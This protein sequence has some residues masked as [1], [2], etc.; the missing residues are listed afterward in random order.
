MAEPHAT[1]RPGAVSEAPAER[2]RVLLPRPFDQPFDYAVPPERRVAPGDYVRVPLGQRDA[3][4]VVWADPE[5]AAAAED[6]PPAERLRPI[7]HIHDAPPMPAVVRRFVAWVAGYTLAPAGAV[8]RMAISVPAALA[9]PRPKLGL[10][11]VPDAGWGRVKATAQRRRVL[12]MAAERPGLTATDLAREAG[13]G[14][15]VVRGLVDAGLLAQHP[16]PEPG[17]DAVPDTRS[18]LAGLSA[19]Q[20]AA[21]TE[22]V[23]RIRDGGYSATLLDGVT[24]SGKTAVYFEAIAAA[25][26]RGE[27]VLVLLPEI[28][29]T[30]HLFARFAERF[31]AAPAA[32]HSDLSSSQRRRTWRAVA[33]GRARVV[34]GARSALFLPYPNLGLIVVDEEHESAFKQEEGVI[35]H[36]RDMAVARAWLGG[37]PAVLASA[38]PSLETMMNVEAGR[39]HRVSL[40]ERVGAAVLPDIAT[41]DLKRDRPPARAWLAEPVRAGIRDALA[42][43]E[44]AMLFLNRRGYAP[45]VLCRACGF[46]LQCPNCTAWLVEHR[47]TGRLACHHC[48]LASPRPAACPDC[49]AE[50]MLVPCGP[51]IERI[52]EEVAYLFPE[53]RRAVVA[54]DTVPGPEAAAAFI[55]QVQQGAVDIVIGTQ[56][57]AKGHHFPGLTF[58]G[59]VDADLGL[60]GGD[61][62]AG[63]RTYQVLHQVA[64]RAGR[65]HRP[66]RVLLQTHEPE[67]PVLQALEAGDRDGFL[68]AEAHQR[69][70]AGMPPFTRLVAL[71]V[72]AAD[73]DSAAATAEALSRAAPAVAEVRILGP[74]D[75]P[76][77][78]L[79]GR[80]RKRFSVVAPRTFNVQTLVRHWLA[81][82]KVPNNTRLYVDVDPYSFL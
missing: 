2:A 59:V 23:A 19:D 21:A 47:F 35:Y 55:T 16:V 34:V 75:P 78:R 62:R 45:L 74:S 79:R 36:G 20:Q 32:W 46:R 15:G 66:G 63:E 38:T 28:A 30:A 51:G 49:G 14:V 10:H 25:L 76:L 6:G 40:P 18:A 22:L 50:E 17:L 60:K 27:Q 26:A 68:H 37:I 82:V 29:L 43:G 41:V 24:G 72:N 7:T 33:E 61:L 65:A 53:A 56:I 58:I 67:A 69:W 54:S 12:A 13:C 42:R 5:Q 9:P 70:E 57:V 73:A 81:A 4:G 31:G 64:G 8:L 39:Y 48:G 80:V 1:P 3:D 11:P 71:I 77:A 52:D 44:Q